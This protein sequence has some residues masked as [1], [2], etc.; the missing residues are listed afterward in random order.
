M[1]KFSEV[2]RHDIVSGYIDVI[3][4]GQMDNSFLYY[5]Y[6]KEEFIETIN[7]GTP[8]NGA[9]AIT[10]ISVWVLYGIFIILFGYEL[11]FH[12]ECVF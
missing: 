6:Y 12:R 10:S 9:C 11:Q 3:T 2:S 8:I 1:Q 5:K 7:R 4:E